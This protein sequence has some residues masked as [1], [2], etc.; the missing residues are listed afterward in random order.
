MELLYEYLST[1]E[2][3]NICERII[4]TR[5]YRNLGYCFLTYAS[6]DSAKLAYGKMQR[7]NL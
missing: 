3:Q 4:N 6:T 5:K 1:Q 7:K 2:K